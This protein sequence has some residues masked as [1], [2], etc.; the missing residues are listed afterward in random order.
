MSP[1]VGSWSVESMQSMVNGALK[2]IES[3]LLKGKPEEEID[4]DE[5]Y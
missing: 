3:F 5:L 4:L 2:N 1:H